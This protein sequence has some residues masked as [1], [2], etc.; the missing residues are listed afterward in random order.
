MDKKLEVSPVASGASWRDETLVSLSYRVLVLASLFSLGRQGSPL[1][2]SHHI[3]AP[4]AVDSSTVAALSGTL[5]PRSARCRCS[6]RCTTPPS[7][8]SLRSLF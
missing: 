5:Q 7:P 3:L 6:M 1:Y 2:E 4:L 8:S